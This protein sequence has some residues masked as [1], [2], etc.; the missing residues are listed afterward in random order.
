MKTPI[1]DSQLYDP[2][3]LTLDRAEQKLYWADTH[4]ERIE[5]A[6]V[7]GSNREVIKS[8]VLLLYDIAISGDFIYWTS[9]PSTVIYRAE[10][11]TGENLKELSSR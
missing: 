3:A 1:I 7:D 6:D 10:K 11:H 4:R 9:L 2:T 5:R 8:A